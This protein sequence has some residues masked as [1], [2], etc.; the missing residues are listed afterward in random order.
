MCRSKPDAIA[1][2]FYL[3]GGGRPITALAAHVELTRCYISGEVRVRLRRGFDAEV[4]T[5][6]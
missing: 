5:R 3:N 4:K 2:F 1:E 6:F